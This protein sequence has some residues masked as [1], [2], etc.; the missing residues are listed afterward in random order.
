MGR[1]TAPAV[2]GWVTMVEGG[3]EAPSSR[4]DSWV[5][6]AQRLGAPVWGGEESPPGRGMLTAGTGR[7]HSHSAASR[8]T[9]PNMITRLIR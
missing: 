1:R 4:D 9:G 7:R 3:P 6:A 5:V 8:V 2:P